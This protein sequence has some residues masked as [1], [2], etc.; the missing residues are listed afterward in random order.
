LEISGDDES[1]GGILVAG[2][3]QDRARKI[4]EQRGAPFPESGIGDDLQD[5]GCRPITAVGKE[6]PAACVARRGDDGRSA[7]DG[8]CGI[9]TGRRRGCP[10]EIATLARKEYGTAARAEGKFATRIAR[11]WMVGGRERNGLRELA[12]GIQAND[13]EFDAANEEKSHAGF[14]AI[15]EARGVK[16]AIGGCIDQ[17]AFDANGHYGKTGDTEGSTREGE[18]ADFVFIGDAGAGGKN[19]LRGSFRDT[20][21]EKRGAGIFGQGEVA[22]GHFVAEGRLPF[23]GGIGREAG[24]LKKHD[25]ERP[26]K[27]GDRGNALGE[28]ADG[29]VERGGVGGRAEGGDCGNE[30][31]AKEETKRDTGKADLRWVHGVLC[32]DNTWAARRW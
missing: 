26:V 3:T 20:H 1:A 21:A 28:L 31:E 19:E 12:G 23:L 14:C 4:A 17:L 16:D 18:E 8:F 6:L 7:P 22:R 32:D 13:G 15:P 5:I 29:V 30:Q 27:I 10:S 2:D 9:A 25:V 11:R 24:I